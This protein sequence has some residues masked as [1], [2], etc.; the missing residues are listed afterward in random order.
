MG[1]EKETSR[2]EADTTKDTTDSSSTGSLCGSGSRTVENTPDSHQCSDG[3]DGKD[4]DSA[5][6]DKTKLGAEVPNTIP[7]LLASSSVSD[8]SGSG[9]SHVNTLESV[10]D[11]V[12][13]R[14]PISFEAPD[15][16]LCEQ[17]LRKIAELNDRLEVLS[18]SNNAVG[19]CEMPHASFDLS[20]EDI[21][22]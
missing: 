19:F 4:I 12:A 9:N 22:G 1:A 11:C 3:D 18:Q 10:E 15:R 5:R 16:V 7:I 14:A 8:G 13:D 20:V 6:M 21:A 17:V 2:D